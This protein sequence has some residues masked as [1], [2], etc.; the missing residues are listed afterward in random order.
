M[1]HLE[2]VDHDQ[3]FR[4]GEAVAAL[5]SWELAQPPRSVEVRLFWYTTGKGTTDTQIVK[6]HCVDDPPTVDA[7]GVELAIPEAGPYSFSGRLVSLVWALEL[8]IQPGTRTRR[9]ELTVSPT[10]REIDLQ[11]APAPTVTVEQ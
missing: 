7:R 2:L 9:L 6:A 1:P 4:P 10:G 8:V 3:H 11:Q 5:A